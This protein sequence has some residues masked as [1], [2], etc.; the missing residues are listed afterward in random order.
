LGFSKDL[1]ILVSCDVN[2]QTMIEELL[3]RFEGRR[4]RLPQ[5]SYPPPAEGYVA[6]HRNEVFHSPSR[7]VRYPHQLVAFQ[8]AA[9]GKELYLSEETNKSD[10]P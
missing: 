10:G 3:Y 9:E 5:S 6:W 1:R 2:G 8:K 4:L 7:A